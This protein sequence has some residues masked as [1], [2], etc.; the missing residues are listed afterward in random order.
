MSS[1]REQILV[2]L[3]TLLKTVTAGSISAANISRTRL[4]PFESPDQMPAIKIE[5]G[6]SIPDENV[7]GTLD[8][9]LLVKVK[10]YQKGAIPDLSAD[11][12]TLSI[13]SKMMAVNAL[14]L[15]FI[16]D[17]IPKDND[18][19]YDFGDQPFVE[20]TQDFEILYRTNKGET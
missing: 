15:S 14:G 2:A 16:T 10:V 17:I 4:A 18:P 19:N 3:E 5:Q 8:W 20:I 13:H 9:K 1:K 11:V 12:L 7:L 6:I